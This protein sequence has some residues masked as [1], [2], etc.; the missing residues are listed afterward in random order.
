MARKSR[1]IKSHK[2]DSYLFIVD[3]E[4]E[5][6]YLNGMGKLD[7]FKGIKISPELPSKKSLSQVYHSIRKS[8]LAEHNH[9][10]WIVDLDT[11]INDNQTKEFHQ[12]LDNLEPEAGLSVVINNPSIEFWF[13]LHFEDTNKY[14]SKSQMV[15]SILRARY[16][17]GYSK[18]RTYLTNHKGGIFQQLKEHIESACER[19]YKISPYDRGS[20]QKGYSEMYM[21]FDKLGYYTPDK[22][23]LDRT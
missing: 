14:F 16:L 2:R 13:L 7:Q 23:K 22:L 11:I 1:Y 8:V 17:S 15:E 9:I 20:P 19:S 5:K 6:Y 18:K 3:G 21:I 4:T 12:Y 10:F